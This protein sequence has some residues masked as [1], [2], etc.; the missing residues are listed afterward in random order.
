MV[1][2][3]TLIP[4][5]PLLGFVLLLLFGKRLGYP[6]AGWLGTIAVFLAFIATL[7]TWAGLRSM[8]GT[9]RVHVQHLF[10]WISVGGLHLG[11][12][13]Y[14]DPLSITMALFVTGV[15]TLIH[16]YS[17]GY[18]KGDPR[19]HQ[20]FVYLNLFVFSMLMLVLA[21]NLPLAFLGWEGVGACSYW[22]I[23]F[24]FE[25]PSAAT[26][27]KK[28]FVVN[29]IG[30]F[31]FLLGMFL[32]FKWVGTLNY[33]DL[34]GHSLTFSKGTATAIMLLFFLAAA[35][36]SAQLPLFTWLVD[37]MEGPTPVSALIHAA[38]MVTAG[39]YLMARLSPILH[40]APTAGTVISV[41][42]VATAFVAA[43]A[44]TSQDDIK[45]VLAYSTVSQLGYM[46][47]GI[48]TGAYVAAIFLMIT[49]AFY[50]ALLF[51]GA[52]SVIHS[53]HDEQNIKRMG[54]LRRL[55][56]ITSATFIIGWL[57][58]AG[59]PPFSGFWS[60]GD[61][62]TAAYQKSPYLWFVG[63]V[64][65]VLTAYYM[66]REVLLV[67]YGKPRWT[68]TMKSELH[69][70]TKGD[71]HLETPHESPKIMT[72]PLVI[73]AA[74]AVVGGVLNLPFSNST[75][76]L[77]NWLSPVFGSALAPNTLS[78]TAQVI[79]GGLDAVFAVIGIS[80]AVSL[81]RTKWDQPSLEPALLKRA[82]G[83]DA[84]YD[85]L[86]AKPS[87]ALALTMDEVVDKRLIDG[88][89]MSLASLIALTSRALKR[90]QTGYVRTYA[91]GIAL[92]AVVLLGYA[93]ARAG[94]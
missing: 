28:A 61:V 3:V 58:I 48:G 5:L 34:F 53:M 70:E 13:L 75:R 50:K 88:I 62:L 85:A 25:R 82:W 47:L 60:K 65:A 46:M 21:G 54:Q 63:A 15:A 33:I 9:S 93:V 44:A 2:Y 32:I 30:D 36:K 23:S 35:G 67:F 66:G 64:T 79:L 80:I 27:G 1:S 92:G 87:T 81:W 52:G 31:G 56:P 57:S 49:H 18:M 43:A 22:L 84:A 73:L 51:L 19:F 69:G 74:A 59:F 10:S 55:M 77:E 78:G 8:P 16:G 14:L 83:I 72:W 20:F 76:V 68:A 42:G 38:T 37:A 90:V 26:A 24:W 91:L 29:R 39:V 11:M 4:A 89:V 71:T 41:V 12:D 94:S 86:F 45:K 7:I 17:I 40:L 6:R